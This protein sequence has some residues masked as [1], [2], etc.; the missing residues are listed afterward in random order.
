MEI[1]KSPKADIERKKS[2][3]MEFGLV[4]SLVLVWAAFEWKSYDKIAMDLSESR[5]ISIEE[6]MVI[7]TTQEA[8]PPP[9]EPSQISTEIKVVDDDVEIENDNVSF[10]VETNE[11]TRV[12]PVAVAVV[13]EEAVAEEEIFQVVEESPSFPG[14]EE[15]L[16]EF[17]R[18]SLSYPIAAQESGIQGRVYIGFVVEK[19]GSI[20]DVTVLRGIG[21]GCDEAAVNV[22]KKLPKWKAGKQRGKAVRCRFSIPISFTLG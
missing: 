6:D 8:P 14:G 1:K 13:V 5:A 3:Y 15:A 7:Q 16:Q 11:A 22:V 21:G 20:T 12:V 2:L 9:P 17:I 10:D 19:D 18:K 4:F